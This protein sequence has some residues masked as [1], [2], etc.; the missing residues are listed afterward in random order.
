MAD[1]ARAFRKTI[2]F[3]GGYVNDPDDP[4]GETYRGIARR[5]HPGWEGWTVI[6]AAKNSPDF[7][8]CLDHR[9]ALQEAVRLF[10]RQQY[11]D[12]IRGNSIASQEV[13]DE[14]FEAG[15]NLGVT[16]AVTFLQT[17]LNVLNRGQTLYTDV[18]EDGVCGP[19][20]L[21][22]LEAYLQ[23]EPPELVITVANI[24]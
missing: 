11:W 17:A 21:A 9:K 13:A 2:R 14:V 7:P 23:T 10:Y 20:T 3:E 6:D 19:D 5:H 15:V 4:G 24:L 16:R 18:V 22:A 12:R 8:G 1:F